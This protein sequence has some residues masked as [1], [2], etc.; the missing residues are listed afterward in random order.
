VHDK[1]ALRAVQVAL[2]VECRGPTREPT[3]KARAKEMRS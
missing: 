2:L 1:I 3:E